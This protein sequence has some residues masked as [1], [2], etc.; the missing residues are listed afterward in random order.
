[1]FKTYRKIFESF[2]NLKRFKRLCPLTNPVEILWRRTCLQNFVKIDLIV[3]SLLRSQTIIVFITP[4]IDDITRFTRS[5]NKIGIECSL[6]IAKDRTEARKS[7]SYKKRFCYAPRCVTV[8]RFA[9]PY[10]KTDKIRAFKQS[11]STSTSILLWQIW[12]GNICA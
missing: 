12:P 4:K 5:F 2:K 10:L 9:L 7:Y 8:F 1:M 11:Q 3:W 6:I